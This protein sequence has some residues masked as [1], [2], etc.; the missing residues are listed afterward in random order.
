MIDTPTMKVVNHTTELP[1]ELILTG[2]ILIF[3]AFIFYLGY[4]LLKED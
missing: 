1:V 3:A 4:L 2:M